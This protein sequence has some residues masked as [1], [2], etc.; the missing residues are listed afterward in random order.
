MELLE[1]QK[2]DDNI[3]KRVV[4]RYLQEGNNQDLCQYMGEYNDSTMQ[5]DRKSM[6]AENFVKTRVNERLQKEM[7]ERTVG[8]KSTQYHQENVSMRKSLVENTERYSRL[9]EE[10]RKNR[11]A[12]AY[13]RKMEEINPEGKSYS[14]Y[15]GVNLNNGDIL[16]LRKLDK[17]G[18]D[19]SGTYLYAGY[20]DCT[21]N[22]HDVEVLRGQP[23]GRYI[24]FET[25]K[26]IEDVVNNGVY[27][28]VM[29]VLSLLSLPSQRDFTDNGTLNYIGSINEYGQVIKNLT[30]NSPSIRAKIEEMRRTYETI[31][32]EQRTGN[33]IGE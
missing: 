26:R 13:L 24:C 28:E 7:D 1:G 10:T 31:K 18:K 16:R 11:I 32:R 23:M 12:N 20:L 25:K 19:G 8:N 29:Q 33:Q 17:V 14:A 2:I 15:N 21:R 27:E 4:V 3:I 22:E 9:Q 6:V 5:V 30:S